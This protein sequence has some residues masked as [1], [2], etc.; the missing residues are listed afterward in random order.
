MIRGAVG[1]L[2][3]AQIVLYAFF[4]F[5]AGLIYYLRR[6]DRR[7]G[8]PLE[9]E[10]MGRLKSIEPALIPSPKTFTLASGKVIK[11]P[12]Y[13]GDSRPVNAQKVEPWPGAPLQPNGDPM[14]AEVGPGSYAMRADETDKAHD[15]GDLIVPFRVAT[16]F[17]LVAGAPSPIGLAVVGADGI[18]GGTVKDLWVDRAESILR[19]YEVALRDAPSTSVLLPVTFSKVDFRKRRV[20]VAAL[21]GSQLKGVPMTRSPDKVTL[22]EEEKITA[23]YGAGTL[24]AT[25]QRAEPL[26]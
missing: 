21:L 2:D 1:N 6:E 19:Y 7:E 24:Y 9:S 11:A 8:Y 20:N 22:L 18:L 3:V 17:S 16:N 23:Y 12:T 5:F 10:A 14:K 13:E 26:I 15:G 4:L 25:P